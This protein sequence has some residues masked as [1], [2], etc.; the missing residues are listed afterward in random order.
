M[1][2]ADTAHVSVKYVSGVTVVGAAFQNRSC[3]SGFS[4]SAFWAATLLGYDSS[5]GFFSGEPL[6]KPKKLPFK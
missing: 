3:T 1:P 2:Q 5:G 4:W 6:K